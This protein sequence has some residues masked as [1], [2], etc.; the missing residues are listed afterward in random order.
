MDVTG[1]RDG[2]VER[3][4]RGRLAHHHDVTRAIY[5]L[6]GQPGYAPAR[7]SVVAKL[8]EGQK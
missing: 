6:T 8:R 4:S 2:A 7:R 3:G 5:E 1:G